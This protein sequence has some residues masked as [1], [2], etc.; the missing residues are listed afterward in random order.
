MK[1]IC[2]AVAALLLCSFPPAAAI[3]YGEPDGETHPYVGMLIGYDSADPGWF[4]CTGTLLSS[5]V[6]LTA[7][8]CTAGV[9]DDMWVTFQERPSREGWPV[10]A[11]YPDQ[12]SLDAARRSYLDAHPDFTS[13]SAYPHPT[14]ANFS[15]FP[16]TYDVGV[17]LLDAAVPVDSFGELAPLGTVEA[18]V[19]GAATPN[20][21]IVETV[22]YGIQAVQ[23]HP[24]NEDW[25]YRSTSRIVELK[26]D[27][28][29]AF[30]LHTLNNPSPIGGRGGSCRGDSGGPVLVPGT[31]LVVAVVSWGPSG[32]CH[33]AD[34]S[35]RVDTAVSQDFVLPF[36]G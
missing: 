35:W 36:V 19:A 13:G 4:S 12:A 20:D 27:V 16:L 18:L 21:A 25:R 5:S 26:S 6:V 32:T 8:H 7:G 33:G 29:R 22:G 1:R 23:P 9:G 30:N 28:A 15:E 14:Y 24:L 11:D 10:A 17:V 3:T 34:Y 31:N 2:L